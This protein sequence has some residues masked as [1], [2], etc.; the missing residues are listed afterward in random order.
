[1]TMTAFPVHVIGI[2]CAFLVATAETVRRTVDIPP[3]VSLL[4]ERHARRD[5][6]EGER[7]RM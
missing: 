2:V 5:R 4:S 7:W 1:V 3:L 6:I